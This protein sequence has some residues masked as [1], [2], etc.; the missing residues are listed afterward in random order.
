MLVTHALLQRDLEVWEE[1]LAEMMNSSTS[2]T[3]MMIHA[4]HQGYQPAPTGRDPNTREM[5]P[6]SNA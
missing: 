1:S 4:A 3:N 6:T 2:R 5:A